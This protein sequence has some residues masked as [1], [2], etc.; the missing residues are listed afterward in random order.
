MTAVTAAMAAATGGA[1]LANCRGLTNLNDINR[2]LHEAR[3][4]PPLHPVGFVRS[5][6]HPRGKPAALTPA[7]AP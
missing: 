5:T 2:L 3:H 6:T 7:P 4:L 1:E